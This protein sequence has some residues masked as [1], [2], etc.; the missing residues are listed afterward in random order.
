MCLSYI[1]QGCT[2]RDG[3]ELTTAGCPH[4]RRDLLTIQDELD[5]RNEPRIDLICMWCDVVWLTPVRTA[6]AVG[7]EMV[8]SRM[9]AIHRREQLAQEP[10][11]LDVAWELTLRESDVA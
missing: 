10:T 7:T 5:E 4:C 11:A 1:L 8:F 3:H 6:Q 9:E 2:V